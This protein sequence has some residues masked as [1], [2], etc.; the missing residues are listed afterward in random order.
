M[1]TKQQKSCSDELFHLISEWLVSLPHTEEDADLLKKLCIHYARKRSVP[2]GENTVAV[3]AAL[4]WVYARVNFMAE[5]E[6]AA[7]RQKDIA[8][9]CG[10]S[11]ATLSSKTSVIMKAMHIDLIDQRYA[12]RELYAKHP[13][14]QIAVDPRS[15]LFVFRN[16]V[17]DEI[18]FAPNEH[19][20]YYDAMEYLNAEDADSALR[21][22]RKALDINEHSVEA[23]VGFVAAYIHK[24]NQRK[25]REYSEYAFQETRRVFP[26]WPNVLHWGVLENRQYLR[27]INY[28]AFAHWFDDERSEAESLFQ[29]LLRL[30]PGDN[31]GVR[32]SLACFYAGFPPTSADELIDE[33]NQTQ[34]WNKIEHLLQEQ[35]TLYHFWVPVDEK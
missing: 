1:S 34:N 18:P 29:L 35:N 30:N 13:A 4:V 21:L 28:M 14:S 25:A 27:A 20:Y 19:D 11:S 15:G 10:I 26:V 3:A 7:W 23:Y 22:L 2:G 6:G 17:P 12:R 8:R 9:L 16:D 32:Y 24:D 5:H 31:Q 33:G